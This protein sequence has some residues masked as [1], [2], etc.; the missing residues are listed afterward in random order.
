MMLVLLAALHL[1]ML[2]RVLL[3]LLMVLVALLG[4]GTD[5]VV[6]VVVKLMSL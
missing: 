5:A 2:C 6:G 3:Q 1:L 4:V